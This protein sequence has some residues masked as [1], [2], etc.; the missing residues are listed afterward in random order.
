MVTPEPEL[1][2]CKRHK[3]VMHTAACQGQRCC[4][5]RVPGWVTAIEVASSTLAQSGSNN[6][7]YPVCMTTY[8]MPYLSNAA[9]STYSWSSTRLGLK[10]VRIQNIAN[11]QL[12]RNAR[13]YSWLISR[14]F[15]VPPT[16]SSHLPPRI[17]V[18]MC[19]KVSHMPVC[20]EFRQNRSHN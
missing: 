14:G 2:G 13:L 5:M 12:L 15:P 11:D 8:A 17:L 20:S 9:R 4:S 19:Y 1:V 7:M 3:L 6:H 16:D 18:V 10:L